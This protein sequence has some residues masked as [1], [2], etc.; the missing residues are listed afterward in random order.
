M[1]QPVFAMPF[2]ALAMPLP[3]L[4]AIV[5]VGG[6]PLLLVVVAYRLGWL[7]VALRTPQRVAASPPVLHS[8]PA[9][10]LSGQWVLLERRIETGIERQ[11][12]VLGLHRQVAQR[13]GALDYEIDQ[14][15]REA[16]LVGLAGPAPRATVSVLFPA[17]HKPRPL[18]QAY[19]AYRQA[20]DA[21]HQGAMAL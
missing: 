3:D 1:I 7:G 12:T 16:R 17:P 19:E 5:L 21:A 11:T 15:W 4:A 13:I 14:L 6:V 18:A 9:L 2:A 20:A 8:R 10:G